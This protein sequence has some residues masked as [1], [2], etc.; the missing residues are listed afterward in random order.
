MDNVTVV[1][2]DRTIAVATGEHANPQ[3]GGL[4]ENLEATEHHHRWVSFILLAAG[5]EHS[6]DR[7][8]DGIFVSGKVVRSGACDTLPGTCIFHRR[9][10]C[11][12]CIA[13]S[14]H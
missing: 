11:L 1:E 5:H 3:P 10:D 7:C 13:G 8:A 2:E 9:R 6:F 14:S 4:E 12:F